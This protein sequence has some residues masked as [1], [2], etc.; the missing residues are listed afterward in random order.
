M[1][2]KQNQGQNA[3]SLRSIVDVKELQRMQNLLSDATGLAAVILDASGQP[4]TKP[5][6]YPDFCRKVGGSMVGKE[7]CGQCAKNGSGIYRCHAGLMEFSKYLMVDGKLAGILIGG[8]A[9]LEKP[10]PDYYRSILGDLGLNE[11]ECLQALEKVPVRSQKAVEASAELF[12]STIEQWVINIYEQKKT[13]IRVEVFN[14]E[15]ETVQEV[16]RKIKMKARELEQTAVTEKMLSLNASI[17]AGRAGNAGVGFSVVA[18][19]IGRLANES[20]AVYAE[21][22]QLVDSVA[23]SIQAMG[24]IDAL[25]P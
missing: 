15:S 20:S 23:D 16:M 13:Q 7:R 14:R 2:E 4:V 6:N 12:S 21:I 25:E 22:R 18:E 24:E 1:E 3:L 19:E 11:A 17:E 9:L 5:S 10:D 8:Q